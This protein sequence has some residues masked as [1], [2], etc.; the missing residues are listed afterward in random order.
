VAAF[1]LLAEAAQQMAAKAETQS[2]RETYLK[3][4]MDWL[5]LAEEIKNSRRT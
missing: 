5:K 4:A 1:A 3:I 2:A